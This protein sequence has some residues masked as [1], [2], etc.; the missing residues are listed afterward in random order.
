MQGYNKEFLMKKYLV[1]PFALLSA[2][3]NLEKPSDLQEDCSVR[4]LDLSLVTELSCGVRSV[5]LRYKNLSNNDDT[6]NIN[7]NSDDLM[8]KYYEDALKPVQSIM[9]ISAIKAIMSQRKADF[10]INIR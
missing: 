9:I 2:I 8:T 7:D 3:L 10:G 4:K 6:F 5:M 1:P